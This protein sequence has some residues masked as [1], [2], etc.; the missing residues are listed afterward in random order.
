MN[1]NHTK[2]SSGLSR[3]IKVSLY[4]KASPLLHSFNLRLYL[5]QYRG[6]C[7]PAL[8]DF[9]FVNIFII[10]L[11]LGSYHANGEQER[12][13]SETKEHKE[14]YKAA[15][16]KVIKGQF[17]SAANL[18]AKSSDPSDFTGLRNALKEAATGIRTIHNS[19]KTQ[20]GEKIRI[21]LSD[22]SVQIKLHGV[23][24]K[25]IMATPGGG[26]AMKTISI[27]QLAIPEFEQRLPEFSKK[28][29]S[30]FLGAVAFKKEKYDKALEWFSKA[31]T[32][33]TP[34]SNAVRQKGGGQKVKDD[35][36]DQQKEKDIVQNGYKPRLDGEL[37][38]LEK[39]LFESRGLANDSAIARGFM[40]ACLA[41]DKPEEGL[42]VLE[43]FIRRYFNANKDKVIY[44]STE[45][46][47]VIAACDSWL[48]LTN[49]FKNGSGFE[50]RAPL[51][52]LLNS[53]KRLG[54]VSQATSEGVDWPQA[55]NIIE[56][57]FNHD[58]ETRDKF[59]ELILAF[60]VVW[61]DDRPFLHHQAGN[62]KLSYDPN[63][64][65]RYD[66]FKK[67]YEG[68]SGV[69]YEW[70]NWR[71]LALVVDTP[72]P[73]SELKWVRN[74]IHGSRSSW[75][76][77]YKDIEYDHERLENGAYDW[78][79]GPYT[80]E[81][82]QKDGGIC[83]DQAYYGTM[84]AR[85]WGIPAMQFTG[86]GKRGYHAWFGYMESQ[87]S[88]NL[89]AGRYEYDNYTVGKTI[90]PRTNGK[91]TDH[92]ATVFCDPVFRTRDFHIARRLCRIAR[93]C[94]K[95]EL[96]EHTKLFLDKALRRVEIYRT[97]WDLL[98]KYHKRN[99]DIK[100]LLEVLDERKKKFSRYPGQRCDIALRKARIMRENGELKGAYDFLEDVQ[101]F[102]AR[103]R[104]DLANRIFM[105]R[106]EILEKHGKKE[107]KMEIFEE[108]LQDNAD[109][110]AKLLD[111][112][113][114]YV[115]FVSK[116]NQTKEGA[117]FMDNFVSRV[118]GDEETKAKFNRLL[119][120]AERNAGE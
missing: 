100:G 82:I 6:E 57:L 99:N 29:K 9:V 109:Q 38:K 7:R 84:T 42:K 119:K 21:R 39:R 69:P 101:R 16:E 65:A 113:E 76:K 87:R 105:T 30:L 110:G 27:F 94:N 80:L 33:S 44:K 11:S 40:L 22:N 86:R 78:N 64:T 112:A 89:S 61:D 43:D 67:L 18:L 120:R 32:L 102:L 71:T 116:I 62:H 1:D 98:E 75:G 106:M 72:V 26:K 88:W 108:Y 34:L 28:G 31:G 115:E 54:I 8:A 24:G 77:K 85:A 92:E 15:S 103:R 70:L 52:W 56:K 25:R 51:I 118:D 81:S 104:Y 83:V 45:M 53:N 23:T 46:D 90:E 79:N 35:S 58:P 4:K 74:E 19:L 111:L 20:V 2:K 95:F 107:K 73:I 91:M 97:A 93:V 48:M 55:A 36:T 96:D 63:L 59:F 117:R 10:F 17:R 14:L 114:R 41:K 49:C 5:R 50:K 3:H 68:A 47:A 60:A 37:G 13:K 66:H 12:E